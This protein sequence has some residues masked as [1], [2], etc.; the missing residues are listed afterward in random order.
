MVLYWWIPLV[1]MVVSTQC[2]NSI[3]K[4][5]V[6]FML[7]PGKLVALTVKKSVKW[8]TTAFVTNT[9]PK[10]NSGYLIF[11]SLLKGIKAK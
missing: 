2:K 9:W 3:K 10:Y 11:L 8:N 6:V 7:I 5:Y 4:G 1:L